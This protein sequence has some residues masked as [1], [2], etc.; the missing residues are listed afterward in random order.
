M[1]GSV[2]Y[3]GHLSKLAL[4]V[5]KDSGFYKPKLWL[6]E[7]HEFG[8]G[9]GCQVYDRRK[10]CPVWKVKDFCR[11][12]DKSDCSRDNNFISF[13]NSYGFVDGNCGVRQ[14]VTSC[15][16]E[17]EHIDSYS[18]F[19]RNSKCGRVLVNFI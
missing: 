19:G 10:T 2:A 11:K 18:Y 5:A 17:I 1:T 6:G 9:Q 13:C 12:G 14:K 15:Q 7:V 4:S 8:K 3:Y 16:N